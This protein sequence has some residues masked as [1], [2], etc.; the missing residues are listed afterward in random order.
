MVH[1]LEVYV[2]RINLLVDSHPPACEEPRTAAKCKCS[3]L[4]LGAG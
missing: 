2:Q 4:K 1:T 3:W